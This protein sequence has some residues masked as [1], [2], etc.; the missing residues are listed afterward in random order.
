MFGYDLRLLIP[1][2]LRQ[3]YLNTATLGPTP[4]PAS[5]AACAAELEWEEIGPGHVPYYL[6]AREKAR[7]FA[8]RIEHYMPRG[9]VSLVENNSEAIL[10][11]MWGLPWERGDEVITTDHEHPAMLFSLASL[12][13]RFGIKVKV[14]TVDSADSLQDQ[15]QRLLTPKTRLVAMSHVSYLTGWQLPVEKLA[16]IIHQYPRTRFLV[17][18]AQAL[19]NILINP[20]NTGADFYVFCGHKWM[21]APPGWAGLWVRTT[22]LGELATMWPIDDHVFNP[23]DLEHGVWP[24]DLDNGQ[25]LEFGS[26]AWPRVVGW[27]ITW[28]YFEEEGFAHQSRYQLGLAQQLVQAV[29][30]LDAFEVVMPPQSDYRLTALVTVRSKKLGAHLAEKLWEHNVVVKSVPDYQGIRVALGLFNI[31]D[32]V[33]ALVS[34][35]Q[36]LSE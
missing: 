22:R 4:T 18:G 28:D 33:N 13:R 34:C 17:D 25:G 23:K 7:Q 2:A 26:R 20:F 12:I 19:G 36:T 6:E 11:V 27:S 1:A 5:A 14:M 21:M 35:L 10:R 3:T 29:G 9:T 8:K 30:H 15:L 24:L 31:P 32:D 16:P